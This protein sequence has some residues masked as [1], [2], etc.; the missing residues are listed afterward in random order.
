M[1]KSECTLEMAEQWKENLP[2]FYEEGCGVTNLNGKDAVSR[3]K[4]TSHADNKLDFLIEY[5]PECR[6]C[7]FMVDDVKKLASTVKEQKMNVNILAVNMSKSNRLQRKILDVASFPQL[8]LYTTD[9]KEIQYNEET[10]NYDG[11]L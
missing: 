9:G 5:H 4:S 1:S 2:D 10:R 8:R 7:S 6:H 3:I 11:M